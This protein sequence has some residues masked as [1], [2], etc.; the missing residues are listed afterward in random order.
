MLFRSIGIA[1]LRDLATRL[2]EE[3]QKLVFVIATT[4][5]GKLQVITGMST[6][7]PKTSLDMKVLFG[8][9]SP[10]LNVSGGGR[11][12][13]VQAGGPDQ[14]QFATAKAAIEKTVA[15]YLTEKGM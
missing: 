1:G 7:I 9:L 2:R 12:D 8:R 5:E 6:D 4:E 15:D 3:G 10:L 13:L 11:P 14:G